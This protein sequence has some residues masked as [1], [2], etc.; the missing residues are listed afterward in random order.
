M[1]NDEEIQEFLVE[2]VSYQTRE[3]ALKLYQALYQKYLDC[4]NV[5]AGFALVSEEEE[6][7][8][9]VFISER[10]IGRLTEPNSRSS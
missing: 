7:V 4:F 5:A 3:H 1:S 9:S 6:K 8:I 10:F 2:Y